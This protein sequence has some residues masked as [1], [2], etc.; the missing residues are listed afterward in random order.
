MK[1]VRRIW[2]RL[3]GYPPLVCRSCGYRVPFLGDRTER[4]YRAF[5]HWEANHEPDVEGGER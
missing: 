4:A 1:Y 3:F 5:D 2:H